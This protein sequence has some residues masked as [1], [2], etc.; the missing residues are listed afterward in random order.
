MSSMFSPFAVVASAVALAACAPVVKPSESRS[1][2]QDTTSVEVT[3]TYRERILP[4]PGDVLIVKIEDVS[5]ADAP[6]RVLAE[7]REALNRRPSPYRTTLSIPKSK[8]DPRHT[9]AVRVEIRDR[10]GIPRFVTDT[11][12][13]VLTQDAAASADIVL[14]AV[15]FIGRP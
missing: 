5:L 6:A 9:Y 13:P 8:I 11:R 10:S 14:R 1:A 7:H 3:A 2:G 12:Y 4:P 15:E